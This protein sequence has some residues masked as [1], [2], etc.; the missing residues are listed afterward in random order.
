MF[1]KKAVAVAGV[2]V[3]GVVGMVGAQTGGVGIAPPTSGAVTPGPLTG[4]IGVSYNVTLEARM[5]VINN[6]IKD[7]ALFVTALT[8]LTGVDKPGNLGSV[9]V[10]TN[11]PRW[12]VE[13]QALNGLRLCLPGTSESQPSPWPGGSPIVTNTPG[14]AL[15]ASTA[16]T[17]G[18]ARLAVYIGVV[19]GTNNGY[20][21]NATAPAV[22]L[23]TSFNSALGTLNQKASIAKVIG[24]D[25]GA[26][27]FL[28]V[29]GTT[30]QTGTVISNATTGG[31]GLQNNPV[32]GITFLVSGALV[33]DGTIFDP[34]P[35][36]TPSL[37]SKSTLKGRNISGN[38]TET[39]TFT[40]VAG[41]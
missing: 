4:T 20:E 29:D 36:G 22:P 39:L 33:E 7:D 23:P 38:Y 28:Q 25:W 30:G 6:T 15:K 3:V 19:N 11:Y 14:A 35:T 21:G 13:V 27:T 5:S 37:L 9:N 34:T 2:V 12:D 17:G 1:I 8:D 31:F 26:Y 10:K 18:D 32:D 16:A 24:T 40:L 41:F